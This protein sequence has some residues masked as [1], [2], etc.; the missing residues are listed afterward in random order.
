[1]ALTRL[2]QRRNWN[3]MDSERFSYGN[4]IRKIRELRDYGFFYHY[5]WYRDSENG[6]QDQL[7]KYDKVWLERVITKKWLQKN[8]TEI[9]MEFVHFLSGEKKY[10]HVV[11]KNYGCRDAKRAFLYMDRRKAVEEESA[12]KQNAGTACFDKI[13]LD[14][15]AYMAKEKVY[16]IFEYGIRCRDENFLAVLSKNRYK[17]T[18]VSMKTFDTVE[19]EYKCWV[20]EFIQEN[21]TEKKNAE[22]L[23]LLKVQKYEIYGDKPPYGKGKISVKYFMQKTENRKEEIEIDNIGKLCLRDMQWTECF[24]GNYY[25]LPEEECVIQKTVVRDVQYC[26]DTKDVLALWFGEIKEKGYMYR[27]EQVWL[28]EDESREKEEVIKGVSGLNSKFLKCGLSGVLIEFANSQTGENLCIEIEPERMQYYIS[29]GANGGRCKKMHTDFFRQDRSPLAIFYGEKKTSP[30][31]EEIILPE[32]ICLKLLK[33]NDLIE[34]D[35]IDLSYLSGQK[36]FQEWFG[37]KYFSVSDLE[38][39]NDEKSF[40]REEL[41]RMARARRIARRLRY[42]IVKTRETAAGR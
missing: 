6:E 34:K 17:Q 14:C 13:I 20:G 37:Q 15:D 18:K 8:M 5:E 26:H 16:E 29:N 9:S 2:R 25:D 39:L 31:E 7:W 11:W 23:Y 30:F 3:E 21:V 38:R 1:M 42:S 40:R 27:R 19:K 35:Q 32:P 28:A 4:L 33:M 41:E 12:M 10:L 36:A 22:Y 24:L